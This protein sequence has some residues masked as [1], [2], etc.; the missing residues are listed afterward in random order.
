MEKGSQ[1]DCMR[2]IYRRMFFS[3][4]PEKDRKT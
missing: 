3:F 2:L 1:V 4:H